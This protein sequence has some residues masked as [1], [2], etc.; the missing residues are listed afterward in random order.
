MKKVWSMMAAVLMLLTLIPAAASAEQT[1][2][3]PELKLEVTIPDDCY[4]LT[5]DVED[6]H[7]FLALAGMTK[8]EL[9]NVM[10]SSYTYLN[11]FPKS[12]PV[13]EEIV[14]TMTP[15]T[16]K[17]MNDLSDDMINMICEAIDEEYTSFGTRL[18]DYEMHDHPQMK[19]VKIR[20]ITESEEQHRLQ[21][22]TIFDNMAINFTLWSYEG[23]ISR[24]Q[25]AFI[26]EFVDNV[27]FDG[28]A[29]AE[30]TEP[31]VYSDA[32]AEVSFTVPAGWHQEEPTTEFVVNDVKFVSKKDTT[33]FVTYGSQDAWTLFPA[34]EKIGTTRA[35]VDN[36]MLSKADVAEM[37]GV[38]EDKVSVA[39]YNGLEYF[40]YELEQDVLGVPVKV[41][42]AI[43][44]YNG[45]MFLFQ[46]GSSRDHELFSDFEK[47]IRSVE[48]PVI[49]VPT[50]TS[51]ARTTVRTT[52]PTTALTACVTT[53]VTD[54]TDE[55]Q[56]SSLKTILAVVAAVLMVAGI[57]VAIIV[58]LSGKKKP[59]QETSPEQAVGHEPV[60]PDETV[61]H[62][63]CQ[64]CGEKRPDDARFCPMCGTE[65]D[66]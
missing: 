49:S 21:Y 64:N 20:Y 3:L 8:E 23:G 5:R 38:T 30:E 41:T 43:R 65:F 7:P 66:R 13:S 48:Y 16:I 34:E 51:T 52:A 4:Y 28:M 2:R 32:E 17:S 19:F 22:Y 33:C 42:G 35:Q 24:E 54:A 55:N 58:L 45:W 9:L 47:L 25:E 59:P 31:F 56:G 50:P 37:F 40:M 57:A 61:R 62:R 6:D 53:A 36:R 15:N 46:F 12:I 14:T 29:T 1:L 26:E 63:Y 27:R 39:T 18:L 60:L 44:V 11:V 10:E